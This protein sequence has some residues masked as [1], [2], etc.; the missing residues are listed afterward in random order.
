MSAILLKGAA[1]AKGLDEHTSVAVNELSAQGVRVCLAIVRVGEREDDLSYE[2]AAVRRMEK[3]GID[4]KRVELPLSTDTE[5]IKVELEHLNADETVHGVLM[6]RPLPAH[7]DETAVCEVLDAKKDVDGIRSTSAATVYL[8]AG[9]GYAPCTARACVEILKHYGVELCGKNVVVLGRSA[10]IGR[11]VAMLALHENATVTICHSK[12][13]NVRDLTRVADVVIVATGRRESVGA[14]YFTSGQTVIDVGIHES[15]TGDGMVGDVRFSE[16][17]E[18][19]AHI[20]P[21]P[22]GVG[23]VTTAVL[24]AQTVAAAKNSA[25]KPN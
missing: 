6:F 2:R 16:V 5:R 9:E 18:C 22:A 25:A 14:D 1:V 3:L 13:E 21:V 11:P 8:G 24:A 7:I 4:V 12:S 15:E 19:V 17:S 10:V 23:S 20:T